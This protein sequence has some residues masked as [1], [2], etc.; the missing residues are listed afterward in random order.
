MSDHTKSPEHYPPPLDWR[1]SAEGSSLLPAEEQSPD[2]TTMPV[3]KA[4][5][6][7]AGPATASMFFIMLFNIVDAWWVGKLG[8]KALAGVSAASFILWALEAASTLVSTGVNAMVARF[9]GAK[10]IKKASQVVGQGILFSIFLAVILGL[11]GLILQKKTFLLMGLQGESLT[12]AL[13]YMTY[14]LIGL[15]TITVSFATDAAFRGMGDTK[16][17]LKIISIALTFNML[18]DPLLIFGIG[19]FPQM[20][21]SGA[22]LATVISHG[23]IVIWSIFLLTK[24]NVNISL[25]KTPGRLINPNLIWRI[26]KIG[27]PIALSGIMFS[28]SYMFLTFVIT[29]YGAE[30]LAALGLGHRVEGIAYFIS[31]GF[32]F[33]AATLVGQNMGAQKIKQ[34]EEAAWQ[35][36]GIT[37]LF[38]GIICVIFYFFSSQIIQLF[39]NDPAVIREGTNY[40]KIVA[41]FELFLGFEVVFEGAFS[42]AGNSIPP[43][44]ISVPITWARIPLAFL[45]ADYFNMG[46][47]GIW[48]AIAI[49]TAAKGILMALWFKKG[50][51]KVKKV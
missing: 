4:I 29:R 13:D 16:T 36:V 43:M 18:L 38:L 32:S 22:A 27:A 14:I 9:V 19:P 39:I 25:E 50:N 44:L 35:T 17:P 26:A 24:R 42:G 30:P 48:W 46:S 41:L 37:S 28:V 34:A 2:L 10:M 21:A 6:K 31:V 20:D 33:A 8:S 3:T 1:N 23:L 51:W 40:L 47:T 11:G 45:F 49:T 5:L 7:L 15:I 12:A